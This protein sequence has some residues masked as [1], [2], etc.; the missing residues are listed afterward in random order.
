MSNIYFVGID[1]R[2]LWNLPFIITY[3]IV[4]CDFEIFLFLN[5][6]IFLFLRDVVS[7]GDDNPV[8]V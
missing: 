1:Y 3:P 4:D 2:A 5:C 8:G 6:C 7:I